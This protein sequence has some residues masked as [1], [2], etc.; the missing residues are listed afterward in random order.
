MQI[1]FDHYGTVIKLV[2]KTLQWKPQLRFIWGSSEFEQYTEENFEWK[3]NTDII[4]F[5]PLKLN[6]KPQIEEY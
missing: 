6:V 5:E 3:S 1:N 2:Q 4:Y